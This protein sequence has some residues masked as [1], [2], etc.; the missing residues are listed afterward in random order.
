MSYNT[1][2]NQTGNTPLTANQTITIGPFQTGVANKVAGSVF[3][4]QT[5]TLYIEQSF[6]GGSNYDIGQSFSVVANVAQTLDL[7][8]IAPIARARYVNGGTGQGT[9]RIFL[10]AFGNRQAG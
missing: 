1:S 10:R 5:G 9:L 3:A 4:D 6:D 8:V 2:D 7:D